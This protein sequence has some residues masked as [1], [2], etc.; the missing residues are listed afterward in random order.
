M[1]LFRARRF[2]SGAVAAVALLCVLGSCGT[3][4]TPTQT[5]PPATTAAPTT[6]TAEPTTAACEDV[7][8]LK[9]SLEA[10]MKVRPAQDGVAALKTAIANV[11]SSLDAAEASASPIL[12]PRVEQVKT[13][14]AELQTAAS[15]LTTD[16]FKQKAPSIASAMRQVGT[17]TRE[18]SSTLSQSCPGN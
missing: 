3:S 6:T 9:S 10:L 8:A 18:L 4:S 16:N 2:A 1:Q 7:A 12:Q 13:A 11:K 17:A 15:G 14:F 5:G